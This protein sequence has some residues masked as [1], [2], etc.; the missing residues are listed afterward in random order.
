MRNFEER[1]AEIFLRSE[2]RIKQRKRKRKQL[3]AFCIPVCLLGIVSIALIPALPFVS[4]DAAY[5]NNAPVSDDEVIAD[6][7]ALT[8]NAQ[9]FVLLEIKELSGQS[10]Q[11]YTITDTKQINDIFT[12]LDAI[13]SSYVSLDDIS[14]EFSDS[15][16]EDTQSNTLKNKGGYIITITSSD[17][18]ERTFSLT[19]NIL[20]DS[21]HNIEIKLSAAQLT[22][23]KSALRGDSK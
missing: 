11:Y 20:S 16:A 13:V 23:L 4:D 9:D 17:G 15:S 18:S 21:R 12:K 3:L 10:Q 7:D 19:D 22:E 8:E 6:E 14:G 5:E 2:K 1:K